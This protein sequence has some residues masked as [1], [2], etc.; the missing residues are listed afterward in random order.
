MFTD[1]RSLRLERRTN[2][3][4]LNWKYVMACEL[5]YTQ[6]YHQT[7]GR[8]DVVEYAVIEEG[9]SVCGECLVTNVHA[10]RQCRCYFG[11]VRWPRLLGQVFWVSK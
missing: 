3:L 4:L 8:D 6:H 5:P 11:W 2:M 10:Q 7:Q 9:S 1:G